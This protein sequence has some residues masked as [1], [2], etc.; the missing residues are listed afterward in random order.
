[1]ILQFNGFGRRLPNLEVS[2]EI[3]AIFPLAPSVSESHHACTT[4]NLEIHR[5]RRAGFCFIM[6]LGV[7]SPLGG[8]IRNLREKLALHPF[9]HFVR[10]TNEIRTTSPT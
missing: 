9:W 7:T 4:R 5:I 1:M 6:V 3:N 8:E 2:F 10:T